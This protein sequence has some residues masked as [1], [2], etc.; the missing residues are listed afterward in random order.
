M[1]ADAVTAGPLRTPDGA[2]CDEQLVPAY[3]DELRNGADLRHCAHAVGGEA[4]GQD[5]LDR[6]SVAVIG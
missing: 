2:W 4:A 5:G 1:R 6:R 3:Q